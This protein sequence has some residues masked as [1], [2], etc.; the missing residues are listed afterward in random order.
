MEEDDDDYEVFVDIGKN[1][2]TQ[3]I[4]AFDGFF[5]YLFLHTQWDG[6]SYDEFDLSQ[7]LKI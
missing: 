3:Q 5:L 1:H 2:R 7:C 4:V 6:L